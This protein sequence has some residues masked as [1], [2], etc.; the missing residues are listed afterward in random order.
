[1]KYYWYIL[2]YQENVTKDF[3]KFDKKKGDCHLNDEIIKNFPQNKIGLLLI[4]AGNIKNS[5]KS[6]GTKNCTNIK[7]GKKS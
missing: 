2:Y 7:R 1:V 6:D 5:E 3:R 4:D